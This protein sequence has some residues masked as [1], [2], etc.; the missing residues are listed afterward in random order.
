[1]RDIWPTDEEIDA[2]VAEYVK[3]Q[4][5][6]DVSE[7]ATRA[8]FETFHFKILSNSGITQKFIIVN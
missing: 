3:P 6:R 8:G 1:M 7:S 5:F 2:V 4:Q